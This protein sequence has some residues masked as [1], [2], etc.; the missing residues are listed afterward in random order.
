[1]TGYPAVEIEAVF[2]KPEK[3]EALTFTSSVDKVKIENG[4]V[5]VTAS[6]NVGYVATITA[7]SEHFEAKARIYVETYQGSSANG[8]SL[9]LE[10]QITVRKNQISSQS[11][12]ET[13]DMVLFVGDSFFNPDNWWTSFYSDYAKK[14]AYTVGISSTTTEDWQIISEKLVYPYSPKAVVVHCGTND[15]FDDKD[16]GAT[17]AES[18][19]KLFNTYHER[20]PDTKIYWFNIEPR[21]NKSFTEP[22][23]A[24]KAVAQFAEGKDWLVVID[25]ASWCFNSDGSVDSA[26]FKDGV[27]PANEKYALYMQALTDAGLVIDNKSTAVN[28]NSFP[29]VI[30]DKSQAIGNA[31]ASVTYNG[32]QIVNEYVVTGK[33]T[34]TDVGN[35]PHAEF[36][37]STYKYRFLIRDYNDNGKFGVCWSLEGATNEEGYEEYTFGSTPL[38]LEWKLV[39]TAKNAYLY[40]NG[41]LKAVY[42]N[43]PNPQHLYLST[44]KMSATFSDIMVYTKS[45][46]PEVYN[47]ALAAVSAYEAQ[48]ETTPRVVRVG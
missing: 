8:S 9:N 19:I 12:G 31:P 39:F 46:D 47:E 3:A 33:F 38:T 24:N 13:E 41:E 29:D 14:K 37:F 34:L 17:T 32:Q 10:S 36:Q 48:T 26:F 16:S 4:K 25:S 7:K 35:N 18:L 42:Y 11:K 5:Y 2:S 28:G 27:H 45:G 43:V 40:I 1:M 20:M 44:E 15:I 30:R 22:D 21:V 6:T 23:A